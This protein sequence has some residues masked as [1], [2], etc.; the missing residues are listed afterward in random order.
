MLSPVAATVQRVRCVPA[1]SLSE[2]VRKDGEYTR[3][4]PAASVCGPSGENAGPS[5]PATITSTAVRAP[6]ST[7]A[8]PVFCTRNVSLTS[9]LASVRPLITVS[10]WITSES[11]PDGRISWRTP[12]GIADSTEVSYT[13]VYF[14]FVVYD[15]TKPKPPFISASPGRRSGCGRS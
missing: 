6:M 11:G 1:S 14:V 2:I 7:G 9:E 12:P 4:D 10:C 13:S 5:S 3:F 15:S 8:V